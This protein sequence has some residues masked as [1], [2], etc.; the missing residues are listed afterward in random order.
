MIFSAKQNFNYYLRLLGEI[1]YPRRCQVCGQTIDDGCFCASCRRGFQLQKVIK[2][3]DVL[4]EIFLLYKYERQ[5]QQ[6]LHRIKFERQRD[7]LP[8]LK[9]EACLSLPE[10]M[11]V[12]TSSYDIIAGIPTSAE[13]RQRRGFDVPE[14]IFSSLD[15]K[16]WRPNLL[17][18]IRPTLPLY[19]LEPELRRQELQGC[20]K[21]LHQVSGKKILLCDDIFTTGS[22]MREAAAALYSAG[23][24]KVSALA[25]AASRD[26][27]Q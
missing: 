22:T 26:N 17:Q 19:E 20:F 21:V 15:R 24:A 9:E 10:R 13:R 3:D 1:F 4:A 11:N 25:F 18:R 6:I 2:N 8:C 14:A 27:W 5:L 16:R 23:A 7:F 12:F